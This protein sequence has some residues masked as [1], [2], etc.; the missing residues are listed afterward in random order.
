[1][2]NPILSHLRHS[3]TLIPAEV[4]YPLGTFFANSRMPSFFLSPRPPSL[5]LLGTIALPL[6]TLSSSHI[7]ITLVP[8]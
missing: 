6:E 2:K 3:I 1:M 8:A 4:Y 7:R 5:L